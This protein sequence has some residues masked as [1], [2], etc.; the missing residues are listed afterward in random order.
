MSK[1]G[2]NLMVCSCG[3]LQSLMTLMRVAMGLM[4]TVEAIN[5]MLK[6]MSEP[7]CWLMNWLEMYNLPSMEKVIQYHHVSLGFPIKCTLLK[8]VKHGSLVTFHQHPVQST[9][10]FLILM[11]CKSNTRKKGEQ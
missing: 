8:A 3:K 1:G 11:R 7:R 10:N 6:L 2:K 4:E 5:V 9:N